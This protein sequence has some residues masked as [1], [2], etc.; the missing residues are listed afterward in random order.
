MTGI[1]SETPDATDSTSKLHEAS[2]LPR[3]LEGTETCR[4]M[5]SRTRYCAL[6]LG[7]REVEKLCWWLDGFPQLLLLTLLMLFLHLRRCTSDHAPHSIFP[8]LQTMVFVCP[9]IT[10][11]SQY[12]PGK[13]WS[14]TI[15]S[16]ADRA[17]VQTVAENT[18]QHSQP[19]FWKIFGDMS[20]F[21]SRT[22]K[23][24]S[25][26]VTCR[27]VRQW[28]RIERLYGPRKGSDA[29]ATASRKPNTVIS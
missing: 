16:N 15:K 17:L 6:D 23:K 8:F 2:T 3:W 13:W 21:K 29:K 19:N 27:K 22:Q 4:E 24:L 25:I 12:V 5:W 28:H 20:R 18:G 10:R 9:L 11:Q 1:D 26:Q 7:A 14:Q